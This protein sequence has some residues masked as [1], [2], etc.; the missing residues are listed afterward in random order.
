VVMVGVVKGRQYS[1][2]TVQFV[3]GVGGRKQ[4]INEPRP[5]GRISPSNTVRWDAI[6]R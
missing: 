3:R 6:H 2:Y 4:L 1:A 5:G